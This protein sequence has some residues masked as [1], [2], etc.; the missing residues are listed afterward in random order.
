MSIIFPNTI[1]MCCTRSNRFVT[2]WSLNTRSIYLV[3]WIIPLCFRYI[4]AIQ[5]T[6][7]TRTCP[8]RTYPTLGDRAQTITKVGNFI[9][10]N[11]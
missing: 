1:I 6:Y 5:A 3:R 10:V 7:P 9:H 4:L 8:I 2:Y 11:P